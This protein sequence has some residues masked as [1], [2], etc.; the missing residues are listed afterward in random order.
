[1][2]CHQERLESSPASL[3]LF[4]LTEPK[5]LFYVHVEYLQLGGNLADSECNT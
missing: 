4:C 5:Y 3:K 2:F 1:V